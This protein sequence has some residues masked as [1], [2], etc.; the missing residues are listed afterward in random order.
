MFFSKPQKNIGVA[1]DVGTASVSATLFELRG[2]DRRPHV[3]QTFRRFHNLS[4]K[5]DAYHFGKSTIGQ[6][7]SVLKDIQQFLG[8]DMPR[9]YTV[10]LSSIFY[11]GK[12]ERLYEKRDVP[13]TLTR[14]DV[15]DFLERGKQKF[16]SD[17]KRDD[18]V[19]FE[20]VL[21]KSELNGYNVVNPIGKTSEEVEMWVHFA[22]TSRELYD[23]FTEIINSFRPHA[24][25][26]FSTFPIAAWSLMREILFPDHS[27]MLVDVGGEITEVTFLVDGVITEVLSLPFG[28]FNILFRIS[29]SEHVDLDNAMSLLKGYT[30]GGLDNTVS[31]RIR[32]IIKKEIKSWEEIFERVWQNASRG[33]MMNIQ[34]FFL[35][36]G[37]LISEMKNMIT[38]PLLHPD[39][40]KGLT[41][42]LIS[43]DA[44]RDKFGTYAGFDGPGDFGLLT[45]ILTSREEKPL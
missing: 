39:L 1:F 11:L 10:G 8:K 45:L 25:I 33:L 28:V 34:M 15:D 22:A 43:P 13:H 5:R 4:L 42:S 26:R 29:E 36:G 30:E 19:V 16:L 41:V 37:A 32:A 38:P 35:G 2:A 14:K 9:F 21:M 12:T 24:T 6:F 31:A 7:S 27:V 18:I 20:T 23:K 3:I 44:F 17:L 40:A